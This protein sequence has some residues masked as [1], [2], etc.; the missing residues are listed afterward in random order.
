MT[1]A[2][3]TQRSPG[4]KAVPVIALVVLVVAAV[5]FRN[6]LI[7]WFTGKKVGSEDTSEAVSSSGGG[8]SLAASLRPDP[9]GAGDN[10]VVIELKGADGAPVKDAN[11]KVDV[12][13]PAMG[14]MPEMRTKGKVKSVG[15]GKYEADFDL[16]MAGSW[17]LDVVAEAGG[18]SL[19]V[20]YSL[21]VGSSGL[22]QVNSSGSGGGGD[23][24]AAMPKHEYAQASFDALRKA[25][26][27]YETIRAKLAADDG[28]IADS[29]ATLAAALDAAKAGDSGL[30]KELGEHLTEASAAAKKLGAAGKLA[31]ARDRFGDLSKHFIAAIACDE[32]L[33]KGKLIYKCPMVKGDYNKWLQ[34][35]AP[36]NNPYQGKAMSTCGSKVGL[37][38]ALGAPKPVEHKHDP[39]EIAY[40]T[41]PMDT[42]VKQSRAG[43]CPV[44][45][46]DLLPVT[47]EQQR[48]GELR[49]DHRRRQL[50]GV[51]TGLVLKRKTTVKIIAIGKV[52]YDETRLVDVALKYD[53][54]IRKVYVNRP[55]Q[56]V[57]KGQ[58]LF[59]VYSPDL[60]Q[61]QQ[62]YLLAL[63]QR[64]S[65]TD[66]G[67]RASADAAIV[68]ARDRLRLWDVTWGQLKRIKKAKKPIRYLPVSS[69]GGGYVVSKHVVDGAAFKAGTR[70]YRIADLDR[71]WVEADVYE[72]DIPLVKVGQEATISMSHVSGEHFSGK[73]A[74]VYPFLDRSN[75]TARVRVELK[76][77]NV[78]LK[79]DMFANVEISV[80]R[81]ERLMVPESAVIY[82]GPRRIVFLDLGEDK[83][84]PIAIEVGIKTDG[85]F[86]VHSGLK[87]N[88]KVVISGNFLLSSE[89][90][91]KSATGLW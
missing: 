33:T 45:G 49:I 3:D 15:D 13:M 65:A 55:G 82:S 91:L 22:N 90:R 54:F 84:R 38:E 43:N 89:S 1:T 69:P 25:L 26:D 83:F 17:T 76:N 50:I 9:P 37:A 36:L 64:E 20:E 24:T 68:G 86:E 62:E 57:R 21:T 4:S 85:F 78:R 61:A 73:V 70:L 81:G 27:V 40:Y 88:D 56:K 7:A 30:T 80:D 29:T 67:T 53:G 34:P 42:W 87:L 72:A 74:F 6:P 66:D 79:P 35:K 51:R 10:T 18:K 2:S 12:W 48:T 60:Y 16:A 14:S 63:T 19:K 44:C 71:V 8:L 39:D 59:T 31:D 77:P 5:V 52:T 41:C 46:M 75:R 23:A 47:K 32:R 58:T 11:I 28:N